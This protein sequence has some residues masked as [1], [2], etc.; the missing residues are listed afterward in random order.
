MLYYV[1]TTGSGQ[2]TLGEEYCDITQVQCFTSA[3]FA[4][5]LHR[6][7]PV[8][9]SLFLIGAS[10]FLSCTTSSHWILFCSRLSSLFAKVSGPVF[11]A[12]I[13]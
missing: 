8:D 11:I 5:R 9:F 1:L 13:G 10:F 3:S 4:I 2:Q 12:D 6:S 7:R